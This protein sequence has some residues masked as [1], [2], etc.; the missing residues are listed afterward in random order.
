VSESCERA[1]LE[2]LERYPEELPALSSEAAIAVFR[3][4]QEG[5]ANVLKHAKATSVLVSLEL[6]PPWL[7]VRL[8][9]D[10]IGIPVERLRALQ[11]H[12]LAAMRQRARALGGQ[13]AVLR[14]PAGGTRIEVRLPLERVLAPEAAPQERAGGGAG[15]QQSAPAAAAAS[16]LSNSGRR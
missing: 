12:G 8:E 15:V 16:P 1:G 6:A 3:I 2:Y 14:L 4:V 13:W 10:G 5:L 11:S 9:D 7:V